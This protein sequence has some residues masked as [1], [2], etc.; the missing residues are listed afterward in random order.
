MSATYPY[1]KVTKVDVAAPALVAP[2]QS[3]GKSSSG[4]RQREHRVLGCAHVFSVVFFG[5][6]IANKKEIIDFPL[7]ARMR[8]LLAV[9]FT[10]SARIL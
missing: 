2:A 9:N 3:K 1:G 5:F 8:S 10:S 7:V 6:S 4:S